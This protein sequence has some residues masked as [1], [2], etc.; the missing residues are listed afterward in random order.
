METSKVLTILITVSLIAD[1]TMKVKFKV[2]VTAEEEKCIVSACFHTSRS[3][4]YCGL[5]DGSII[6]YDF[7]NLN[8]DKVQRD[9]FVLLISDLMQKIMRQLNNQ[10]SGI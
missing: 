4:I 5:S 9:E 3:F 10:Q 7:A 6:C 8:S 2:D 1:L